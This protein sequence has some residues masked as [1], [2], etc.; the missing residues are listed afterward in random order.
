MVEYIA[1]KRIDGVIIAKDCF[2]LTEFTLALF[3]N[4]F[5]CVGGHNIILGINQP[6]RC[7]VEIELDN[8]AFVINRACSTVLNRLCHIVNVDI[9][10]EYFT[11][12]TVF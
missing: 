10:T 5:V 6:Q 9:V 3:D 2:H 12:A 4:F 1:Y 7:F 8:T 11:G